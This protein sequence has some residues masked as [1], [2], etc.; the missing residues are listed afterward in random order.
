[1]FLSIYDHCVT[2][3]YSTY[4][5]RTSCISTNSNT[6]NA[7]LLTVLCNYYVFKRQIWLHSMALSLLTLCTNVYLPKRE[8]Y[9]WKLLVILQH[10]ISLMLT[11]WN[12]F[13]Q[14]KLTDPQSCI[15]VILWKTKVYQS[16]QNTMSLVPILRHIN[17]GHEFSPP[18]LVSLFKINPN[19]L[20]VLSRLFPS[21]FPT[22]T[23]HAFYTPCYVSHNP[24]N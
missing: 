8:L 18:P 22:K 11:P 4:E 16:L 20:D 3:W 6:H 9:W 15:F 19:I 14:E 7:L 10:C 13:L 23:H 12:T 5:D 21:G 24:P 17:S 1:M 2:W